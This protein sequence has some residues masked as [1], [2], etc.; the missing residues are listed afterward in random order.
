MLFVGGGW[1]VRLG[2]LA[3]CLGAC[4]TELGPAID[5]PVLDPVYR[6]ECERGG[7]VFFVNLC[8]DGEPDELELAIL[9]NEPG[10]VS[11]RCSPNPVASCVFSCTG[12]ETCNA[13]N[14][15]YCR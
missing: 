15:C 9:E 11:A 12:Q 2:V 3:I 5:V 10:V 4:G 13:S 6:C 7:E 14:G 1:R 8:Y